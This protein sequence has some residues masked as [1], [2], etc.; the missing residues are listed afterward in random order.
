MTGHLGQ[1]AQDFYARFVNL[2]AIKTFVRK[3]LGCQCP[4]EV[5]QQ[6]IIGAPTIFPD[7]NP[8]WDLQMLIGFRLLIS[9]VP[10]SKLR[11]LPEDI[12]KMLQTGKEMRDQHGLNRFRLV[13]LGRLDQA[14][15]E[16]LAAK[17]QQLD[18]KIHLH[19]LE[20]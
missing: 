13:L 2:E 6:I 4:E 11:N 8:G 17:A 19:I 15:S 1:K 16:S 9:L 5:F 3:A 18:E 20:L 10:V 12:T 14:L 7:S